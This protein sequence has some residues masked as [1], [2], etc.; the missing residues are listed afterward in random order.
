MLNWCTGY[1]DQNEAR[2]SFLLSVQINKIHLLAILS[3][4]VH[5]KYFQNDCLSNT[6]ANKKLIDMQ[7]NPNEG[8]SLK[9]KAKAKKEKEKKHKQMG[10]SK[11]PKKKKRKNRTPPKKI[12]SDGRKSQN[13]KKINN[14][15]PP[16]RPFFLSHHPWPSLQPNKVLSD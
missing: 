4:L 10:E 14:F 13:P 6:G 3:L 2:P 8:D 5:F 7:P 1:F 15:E 16:C 11:I 12:R 9:C